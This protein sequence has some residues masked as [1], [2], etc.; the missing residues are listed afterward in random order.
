MGHYF[1]VSW[2]IESTEVA[3]N[4]WRWCYFLCTRTQLINE[5]FLLLRFKQLNWLLFLNSIMITKNKWKGST[6][7]GKKHSLFLSSFLMQ[8]CYSAQAAALVLYLGMLFAMSAVGYLECLIMVICLK[9]H[10]LFTLKIVIRVYQWNVPCFPL[11]KPHSPLFCTYQK[12]AGVFR[13]LTYLLIGL[14]CVVNRFPQ[15]SLSLPHS[16]KLMFVHV[17][18][19]V[20]VPV[21]FSDSTMFIIL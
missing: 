15:G 5:V 16:F 21:I 8:A 2:Q 14:L 19:C 13:W 17:C 4:L 10:K 18:V 3:E 12:H 9:N 1:C 6:S 11:P 7:E 20:L